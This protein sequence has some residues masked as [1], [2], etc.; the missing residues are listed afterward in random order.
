MGSSPL[1]RGARIHGNHSIE[2]RGLIPAHAGSTRI[3]ACLSPLSGAHPRSRGE[4]RYFETEVKWRSGSSPLTRGAP[5]KR[6]RIPDGVGLIPA[7]A[8]STSRRLLL[9]HSRRAHPRSRG[10]HRVNETSTSTL[11][12]SSPLT[13]GALP[14]EVLHRAGHGLIP[15]H[16]GSTR[17]TPTRSARQPAHPRS[18]GEHSVKS[19]KSSKQ[20]GSSPLTR[21][22]LCH[23]LGRG[24]RL[25]LIP[26]HAGST[27][28]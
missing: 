5:T 1:T 19:Q 9:T 17:S 10:E 13:R 12:G 26:A 11:V 24:A 23:V 28:T 20:K 15:A 16:A 3:A 6:I 14:F 2:P 25:G 8:G 27:K 21:G 22:A 18:R 7:H 4:H